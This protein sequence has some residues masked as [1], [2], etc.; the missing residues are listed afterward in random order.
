MRKRAEHPPAPAV[1]NSHVRVSAGTCQ[2]V[3]ILIDQERTGEA[4]DIASSALKDPNARRRNALGVPA[5]LAR[6]AGRFPVHRRITLPSSS[7]TGSDR[8][9]PRRQYSACPFE[10]RRVLM[11]LRSSEGRTER[12]RN[13]IRA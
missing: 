7:T 12:T 10:K 8:R 4:Q 2:E 3:N 9:G 1:R 6:K 11:H 5:S 13:P